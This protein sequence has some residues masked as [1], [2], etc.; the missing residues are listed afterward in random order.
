[1]GA[2]H[3]CEDLNLSNF[4]EESGD[5]QTQEEEEET[6]EDA[7]E[8]GS[9]ERRR[10]KTPSSLDDVEA[11]LKALKLKHPSS[12]NPNHKNVVKLY[13]HSAATP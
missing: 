1:M 4:E 3:S 5:E 2:N 13:N 6:Y 9:S 12:T 7:K 11:K 10:P 8:E